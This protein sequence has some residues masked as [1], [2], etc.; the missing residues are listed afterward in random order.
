[1]RE[2]REAPAQLA[3]DFELT[4][5]NLEIEAMLSPVVRCTIVEVDFKQRR[6]AKNQ[7]AEHAETELILE[8][9][10]SNARRLSW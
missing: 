4:H 5:E 9:V 2:I 6:E 10:L 3:F 8:S 7:V 1:M